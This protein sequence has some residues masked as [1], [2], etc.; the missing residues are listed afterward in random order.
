[1]PKTKGYWLTTSDLAK[2]YGVAPSTI[3]ARM[4]KDKL[5]SEADRFL[6]PEE[7]HLGRSK[8]WDKKV[9]AEDL[10]MKGITPPKGF[11]TMGLPKP[12]LEEGD[13]LLEVDDVMDIFHYSSRTEFQH[14]VRD[15]T[16]PAPDYRYK[17]PF[18]SFWL[19]SSVEAWIEERKSVLSY[20][21]L[22]PGH[23]EVA[24]GAKVVGEVQKFVLRV[25]SLREASGAIA[26]KEVSRWKAQLPA[27]DDSDRGDYSQEPW[28][29]RKQAAMS[30]VN[31]SLFHA[32]DRAASAAILKD[33]GDRSAD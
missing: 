1:M 17:R 4:T 16:K 20:K 6:P 14:R 24:Y 26:Q 5:R 28:E 21:R 9:I 23:Y 13:Q 8:A 11:S 2:V 7:T 15:G 10:R 12:S 22:A 25:D 27:G 32:A 3:C 30:L 31:A 18:P 29:T 19:K 33:S